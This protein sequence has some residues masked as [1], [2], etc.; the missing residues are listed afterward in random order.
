MTPFADIEGFMVK[1]AYIVVLGCDEGT[2]TD[3]Q[4][5]PLIAAAGWVRGHPVTLTSAFGPPSLCFGIDA[6]SAEVHL[7]SAGSLRLCLF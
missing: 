6:V 3:A 4:G 1:I 7:Y 2:E 5:A